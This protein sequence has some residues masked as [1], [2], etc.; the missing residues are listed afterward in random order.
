MKYLIVAITLIFSMS[1]LVNA[2]SVNGS[3]VCRTVYLNGSTSRCLY[4]NDIV[5][6]RGT[7][8]ATKQ[9]F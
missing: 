9:K 7:C 1:G 3:F 2:N 8:S 4:H 5:M 6:E